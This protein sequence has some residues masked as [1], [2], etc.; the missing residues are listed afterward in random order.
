MK[1]Y[2]MIV[3]GDV[4]PEAKGPFATEEERDAAAKSHRKQDPQMNDGLYML[5][6]DADGGLTAGAYAGGFFEEPSFSTKCP[7]CGVGGRLA[8]VE[9]VLATTGRALKMNSPLTDNGFEVP[10]NARDASTDEEVVECAACGER[11]SL[12]EVTL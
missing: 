10:T 7:R 3:V 1:H 9:A 5:D 4:E 12:S 6:V 11:F 8:V 2:L